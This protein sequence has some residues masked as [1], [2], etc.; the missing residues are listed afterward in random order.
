MVKVATCWDDGVC[1]DLRLIEILR[2]YNAKATFNLNPGLHGEE[3]VP[4]QWYTFEDARWSSNGFSG[5][6]FS[7]HELTEIYKG[8]QVASHCMQ[9]ETVGTVLDNVFL[10]AAIDARHYLE[11][12]FQQNCPGFAWPCGASTKATADA[13]LEA[14]FEYG[15]T[16]QNTEHVLSYEHPML[17]NSSCHFL[18]RNFRDLFDKAKA[19]NGVFYFW[20]HSYEMMD[21]KGMWDF[22][23]QKIKFLSEDPEVE[24]IDVV[25]IVRMPKA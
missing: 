24:W 19:E 17:L 20:G 12:L 23:E 16:T 9:H 13:M 2:K 18:N 7:K 4:S 10:K 14:G 6:K 1:T 11:D 8:F 3:R 21:C 22:M 15:R 25:D 5:G